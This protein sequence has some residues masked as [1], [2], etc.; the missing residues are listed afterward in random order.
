MDAQHRLI[1]VHNTF[2]QA[3]DVSFA[4]KWGEVYW[5]SC[6]NANL[7][8]ENRLPDYNMLREEG[9]IIC[10]GTDSLC[11][12][13]QLSI[14]EEIKTI[15][16]YNSYLPLMDI[17]Q[18]GTINGARAL[19]ISDEY[20]TIEEGKVPGLVNLNMN[21]ELPE[22]ILRMQDYGRIDLFL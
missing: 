3:A 6:P 15:F 1:L 12:N 4:N 10:L 7:Y 9:A 20:G 2:T 19:G 22:S 11:S 21:W 17:L 14:V 8:I 18:W 13:W 5:A 16:K